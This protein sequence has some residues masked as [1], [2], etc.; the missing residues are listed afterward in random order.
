[1]T[2]TPDARP[3]LTPAVE[4]LLEDITQRLAELEA[5][6]AAELLVVG[7]AAHGT[8]VASVRSLD[9]VS[10]SVRVEGQRR[11]IEL[12]LRPGFFLAGDAPRRLVT[13]IHELLHLDPH[14]SG[15]LLESK[16]H[17]VRSHAAHEAEARA[18][19]RA[20]LTSADPVRLLCLAHDGEVLLR[21]W[22]I[23]PCD[24]TTRRRFTDRDVF[25]GPVRMHTPPSARGG[26]W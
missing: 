17:R 22:R 4:R 6:R 15:R 3:D 7:L 23:R 11:R 19:A 14:H 2:A 25:H 18:L 21:Q 24:D 8:V 16:R 5:L 12:G 20:Y 13:L 1:M 9:T 10:Q 26:W